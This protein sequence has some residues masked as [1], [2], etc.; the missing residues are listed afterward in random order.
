MHVKGIRRR[1]SQFLG[2]FNVHPDPAGGV[3]NAL[4]ASPVLRCD[5]QKQC[6]L[7]KRAS[8]KPTFG[9]FF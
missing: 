2:P 1:A 4:G 3:W 6:Q 5:L 9:S 8:L 7:E